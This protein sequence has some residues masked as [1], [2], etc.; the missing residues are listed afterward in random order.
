[1]SIRFFGG[2][3]FMN[4]IRNIAII[5]HVD[6]GKTTLVDG[7]LKQT[8][9]F[10][11]NQAEMSQTTILDTN[12][13]EREKGITILAKNT[14]VFY[15]GVKINIIDTPGHA[16]FGGEVERVLNMAD[17]ALL[18]VDAA[19][20]PLP[21]TKFV[22]QKAL[23]T[24]LK[25]ILVINKVDRKDARPQQVLTES[26]NLF[27]KL[28]TETGHLN[29]PVIYTIGREGTAGADPKHLASDL[30]PLFELILAQVPNAVTDVDKPLQM[31][32]S[33]L[34]YDSY[35]GKL[36]IGRVRRGILEVG[37]KVSLV[38]PDGL[39]GNYTVEKMYTSK[40]ITR[41][42]INKAV[43]GDI[44]AIAGIG[45]IE[46]GQTICDPNTPL[47]LPRIQ[48][49]EPTLKVI[50]GANTSPFAGREGKFVTSRQLE[51][52]FEKE[53]ETNLGIRIRKLGGGE[54]EVAGRGELHL[55]ILIETMRRE[56]YEMQVSKP[57][58]ILKEGT[59]P[60]DEVTIEV[61]GGFVGEITSEMGKRR[62]E[63]KDLTADENGETK[64]V[65]LIS[66]RNMLG[67]RNLLLTQTRGTAIINSNFEGFYP[68][69]VVSERTRNGVLVAFETGKALAYSLEA[70]QARGV[71][72][73]DPNEEVYEGMIVGLSTKEKD[74][75]M[76][77]TRGKHLTNTR[78]ANKDISTVLTPAY[79]MSLEQ[80]LDFL[81]DDELLEVTPKSLRLRKKYL[82]KLDRIRALRS[83]RKLQSN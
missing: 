13:L 23:Q 17:A 81:E 28:A 27:L 58:V 54:F 64:I 77:V 75:D 66:Q 31:L 50:I 55:A 43:S 41:E 72:F 19:E 7:M 59:E 69:G 40:G 29:F 62:A 67:A 26:E 11:D 78:S 65:Y 1:M 2:R 37:Q 74:I 10:R 38:T 63:M 46:I 80:A 14:A 42:E 25:I 35:L 30:T 33:T 61:G 56:G 83:G 8:H 60:Y 52:R 76:N 4:D 44:I 82:S 68:Q 3:F 9:T 24:G 21:Q 71:T 47:A 48:V 16:D 36:A 51:E 18:V 20:G 15:K 22:L 45:D 70:A 49:E 6:H 12:E 53:I 73:V 32:V 34:D 79:K 5:A 57:Q 39:V